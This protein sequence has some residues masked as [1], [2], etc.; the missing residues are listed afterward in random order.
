MMRVKLKE[1]PSEMPPVTFLDLIPTLEMLVN[2]EAG[3]STVEYI[4]IDAG[5]DSMKQELEARGIEVPE[6][7]RWDGEEGRGLWL[8]L[9]P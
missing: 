5:E 4:C 7:L 1:N 9:L 6:S 2:I 3:A 8:S